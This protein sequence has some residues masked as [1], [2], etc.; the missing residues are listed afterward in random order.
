MTTLSNKYLIL[1]WAGAALAFLLIAAGW[2]GGMGLFLQ[3]GNRIEFERR[4][5]WLALATCQFGMVVAA[6]ICIGGILALLRSIPSDPT[7]WRN[8]F[9]MLISAVV[10]VASLVSA[11]FAMD[12]TLASVRACMMS[13]TLSEP[14]DQ[15]KLS[16]AP[17][18]PGPPD[19]SPTV[20]AAPAPPAPAVEVAPA[21]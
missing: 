9:P 6:A 3:V 16:I 13:L 1:L 12:G 4:Y 10:I 17:F 5:L 8:Y 19:R 18:S 7:A 21:K 11:K 20:E 2:F 14:Y 15:G